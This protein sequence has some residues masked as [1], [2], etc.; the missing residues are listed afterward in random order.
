MFP[1]GLELAIQA[2]ERLQTHA[3]DGAATVIKA[4]NATY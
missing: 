2:S 3:L 1:L 4:K